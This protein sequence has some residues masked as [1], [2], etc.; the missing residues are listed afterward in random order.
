M[1][2]PYSTVNGEIYYSGNNLYPA[3]NLK[4]LSK[5]DFEKKHS[6]IANNTEYFFHLIR[7]NDCV[8]NAVGEFMRNEKVLFFSLPT[9]T[10]M[11][12]SP[13]ALAN[14]IISD[15]PPFTFEFFGRQ[16]FLTQS[17]QLYLEL[18]LTLPQVKSLYT[19]EKS[20]RNEI[21]DFRHLPEFSH[22]EF[23][24]K[25]TFDEN[26]QVQKDF[27]QFILSSLLHRVRDS[28]LFFVNAQDLKLLEAFC[29]K[30]NYETVTFIEAFSLLKR[31]T[32]DKKYENVTIEN[33]GAYEEI[34]LTELLGN[35]NV[36]VLNFLANE[37][38]F[39]HAEELIHGNLVAKNADFLGAGYGE[40]IGSGERMTSSNQILEKANRFKLNL[41]DYKP[42]IDSRE[43]SNKLHS[44]WGMGIER[45]IQSTLKM[46]AIWN[47]TCFPRVSDTLKP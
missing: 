16:A 33:F 14:T 2:G 5:P 10:R 13:G 46:P 47:A 21:S 37:V 11:I 28:I 1:I 42:Y 39:Y 36:F 41:E 20:F 23:E 44:G 26:I 6:E 15:V 3:C 30:P 27:F 9:I 19:F 24:A 17:S 32:G 29:D 7:I 43:H 38:A 18:A 31:E 22:V 25:I 4:D 40:L 34:K 12:S 45:F 35:K 8:Y